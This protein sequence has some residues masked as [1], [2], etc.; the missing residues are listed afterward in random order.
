MRMQSLLDERP[1][2]A[3][4]VPPKVVSLH[5]VRVHCVSCAVRP[6]CLPV[7]LAD[8]VVIGL[9]SIITSHVRVRKRG[10]LYRPGDAFGALYAI[11]IGMLKTVVLAQDG[12]EQITGFH[13]AG[14]II[15]LDGISS[16]RYDCQAIALED[17]EVCVV[18]FKQ[19]D[20]LAPQEY[21]GNRRPAPSSIRP[22]Y[23]SRAKS[24]SS[25]SP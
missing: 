18:P 5:E 13:M 24:S 23:P 17:S 15:G 16:G 9:D 2:T 21:G 4:V 1:S 14:D 10:A 7:G 22:P 19:L 20:E 8:D 6:Y 3:T 11:R 12:R 25:A